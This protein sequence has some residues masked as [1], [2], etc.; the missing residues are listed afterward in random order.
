MVL[1]L[2]VIK[3]FDYYPISLWWKWTKIRS[4]C[5]VLTY[6]SKM[7][8]KSA[9]NHTVYVPK[10]DFFLKSH[11]AFVKVDNFEICWIVYC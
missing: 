10:F 2:I 8:Q 5:G 9:V 3:Y 6:N 1:Y 11:I 4:L 7:S